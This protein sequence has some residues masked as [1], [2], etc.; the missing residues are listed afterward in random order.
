MQSDQERFKAVNHLLIDAQRENPAPDAGIS[1]REP[2][3]FLRDLGVDTKAKVDPRLVLILTPFNPVFDEAYSTIRQTV[4]EMGLQAVRGDETL[5]SGNILS[6]VLQVM[7]TSRLVIANITGRN[8]NVFYELGIAHALG[9]SVL[10]ISETA[11]DIPFDIR[12]I[13]VLT[14]TSMNELHQRLRN[15][16]VH[17]IARI[18]P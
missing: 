7:V 3:E 6:H 4:E 1:S 17:A 10:I 2:K 12:S 15:W 5:V 14:Y 11:E 13:R 16:I 18:E 9:K 8:P